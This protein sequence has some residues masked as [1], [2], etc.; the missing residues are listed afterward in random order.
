MTFAIRATDVPDESI[1]KGIVDPLMAFNETRTGR[2]D[3]RPLVIAI[4]D[5]QGKVMGGLWGRTAYDWLFVELLFVPPSLRGRGVGA[6]LMRRA[7]TEALRR[8]CHSAWLDTFEFQAR[9]FYERLGF[10]CFAELRDYPAG[11]ARYFMKK[12]LISRS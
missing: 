1:R 11:S 6:D 4:E 9:G 10:T 7:E 12:A 8:G 5:A 3:H 2:N